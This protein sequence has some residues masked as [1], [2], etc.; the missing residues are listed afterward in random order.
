MP[1]DVITPARVLRL[2]RDPR[3]LVARDV[4]RVLGGRRVLDG[5]DLTASPGQRIG[6]VGE[7]GSGKT[8]LLR[9]LAGADEPE[10][11]HV[12]R[13]GDLGLL[14][15]EP[16][17]APG[18]TVRDVIG[19]ALAPTHDL[20]ARLD[21]LGRLMA[22]A[23]DDGAVRAAYGDALERAERQEAWDA[24]RRA[25]LVRHGLGLGDISDDR[26]VTHLSGGERSRLALTALLIRRPDALLL[27]EP[28]NHLDDEALAFLEAHL[29]AMPGVVVA[30]SHDRTFLDAVCTHIVDLDPVHRPGEG[31]SLVRYT[32]AY[33]A[34]RRA[35]IAER[36]RWGQAY[37][38]FLDEVEELTRSIESTARRVAPG[39]AMKDN[40]KMGYDRHGARVEATVSSRV[41]NA[42]QRLADLLAD[43]VPRPPAPLR[44][45]S[46]V[47]A[48]PTAAG[49]DI[50]ANTA[51]TPA[52]NR[53]T[54]SAASDTAASPAHNRTGR[55][56]ATTHSHPDHSSA[57]DTIATSDGGRAGRD[58]VGNRAG[59]FVATGHGALVLLQPALVP[60]RLH[61]D[62]VAVDE[63]DRLLVTGPNG[64]GKSTLLHLLA[65]PAAVRR[66]G[67]RVALLTQEDDVDR[68]HLTPAQVLGDTASIVE[69]GLLTAADAGRPLGQL[70]VGQ[71][72]RVAL[73]LA[74]VRAPHV[75]LL[76]EPSNHLSL[77]LVEDLEAALDVAP[78]AV[79]VATHDRWLR[80]RWSGRHL[81]LENGHAG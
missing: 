25:A 43:Q 18:A 11:G 17:F 57:T 12:S 5:V 52:H 22:G 20:L 41:R 1:A 3:A 56:T 59:G 14:H 2:A 38:E 16:P 77:T 40:N 9:V 79:V 45:R 48:D 51:T 10:E 19:D 65:S 63:R 4:V 37:E 35:K 8:T 36:A 26:P 27:D 61:L 74:I 73:A 29:R 47:G 39:R 28:T 81:R 13:P 15:Q 58:F 44:F 69:L 70:S 78:A 68:P 32:G 23:P 30:A 49:D 33:S 62:R 67:T 31:G 66:P 72:R 6:L 50:T 80:S 42:R 34:Y 60:G 46:A 54:H 71:R 75:L 76:D 24:E 64:A 21:R 7:N 55:G 53:T